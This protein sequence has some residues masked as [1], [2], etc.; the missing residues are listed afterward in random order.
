VAG[1]LGGGDDCCTY[2][3]EVEFSDGCVCDPPIAGVRRM[4][5][6]KIALRTSSKAFPPIRVP[7]DLF[8]VHGWPSQSQPR[9]RAIGEPSPEQDSWVSVDKPR[10]ISS[11][12]LANSNGRSAGNP[13]HFVPPSMAGSQ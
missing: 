13:R 11:S 9:A 4:T 1:A 7:F 6:I 3:M 10:A 2:S 12:V 8:A 5:R